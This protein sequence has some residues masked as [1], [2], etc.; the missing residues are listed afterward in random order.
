MKHLTLTLFVIVGLIGFGVRGE[1]GEPNALRKGYR[2][3]KTAVEP[4]T[5]TVKVKE[6]TKIPIRQRTKKPVAGILYAPTSAVIEQSK[7]T[8]GYKY[9]K[10]AIIETSPTVSTTRLTLPPIESSSTTLLTSSSSAF[11]L[12]QQSSTFK[13]VPQPLSPSLPTI[14][15]SYKPSQSQLPTTTGYSYKPSPQQT[16]GYTYNKSS[17]PRAAAITLGYNKPSSTITTSTSTT[18]SRRLVAGKGY[19]HNSNTVNKSVSNV[20]SEPQT[21]ATAVTKKIHR[22]RGG[23]KYKIPEGIK[24]TDDGYVYNKVVKRQ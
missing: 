24:P 5:T 10:A 4:S 14:G 7:E 21:T 19:R 17:S 8:S 2:Y 9:T 20:S 11:P 6:N 16:S 15:Y 1:K 12:L 18:S 22:G 13:A 3:G 23:Y